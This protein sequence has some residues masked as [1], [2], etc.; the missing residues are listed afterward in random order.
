MTC[1]RFPWMC[2]FLRPWVALH[3][4]KLADMSAHTRTVT[5]VAFLPGDGRFVTVGLDGPLKLWD[6]PRSRN[7]RKQHV[8]AGGLHA[9]AATSDGAAVATVGAD[10]VIRVWELERWSV[11]Q[12]LRGSPADVAA[13]AFRADGRALAAAGTDGNA[14]VWPIGR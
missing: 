6:G 10:R 11:L 4:A 1:L 8:D 5:G 14:R 9:V 3:G 12:E 13:L 7:I 2:S